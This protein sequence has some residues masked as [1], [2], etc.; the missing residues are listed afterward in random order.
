M[1][2]AIVMDLDGVVVNSSFRFKRLNLDAFARKD[3]PAWIK[4][5]QWYNADCR[6]DEVIDLGLDL[7]QMFCSF[8]KPDCVFF[9][10]ARGEGGYKPTLQW[11]KDEGIWDDDCRLIMQPEDFENY[12]FYT[13]S[14]H[15]SFKKNVVQ[16]IMKDYEIVCAVDDSEDNIQAYNDLKI[17]TL[18]FCVP[19][20]RVLV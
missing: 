9:V 8:Y 14:D 1:K 4:S 3:A 7:L 16:K 20:G 15:A 5:V 13:Q 6:G 10:T 12:H 19:I 17:P 2:K 11:L 18:K